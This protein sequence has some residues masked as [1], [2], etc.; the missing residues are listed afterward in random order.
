MKILKAE[1]IKSGTKPIHWP[2]H[3]W[4]EVAVAGRS[5]VGKSSLIN[6]LT[7]RKKLVKISG[8]PGHTQTINF[9][10]VNDALCLVDLPGYGFAKVAKT[11]RAAWAA[12]IN[13][14]LSTRPP[15]KALICI[16]DIRRGMEEDDRML[17]EACAT[18]RIQPILVFTKA[19]KFSRNQRFQRRQEIAT[20]I[21]ESPESLLLY[22]AKDD[23]GRDELWERIRFLTGMP[24]TGE[25][26]Q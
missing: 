26:K 9:F 1:F 25:S 2:E 16:M 22:S 24:D 20:E 19:D 21:G 14:Y 3:E 18:L 6:S 5:N 23:L 11:E 10:N 7:Q 13:G 17:I 4:P 15:L 12:M 8:K